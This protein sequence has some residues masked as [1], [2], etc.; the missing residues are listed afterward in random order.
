MEIEL[1]FITES[2]TEKSTIMIRG[3]LIMLHTSGISAQWPIDHVGVS[4]F[5]INENMI[6]LGFHSTERPQSYQSFHFDSKNFDELEIFFKSLGFPMH[7]PEY[8]E[9]FK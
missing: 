6:K 7:R 9:E 5:R 1:K 8:N 4:L 2:K 3:H